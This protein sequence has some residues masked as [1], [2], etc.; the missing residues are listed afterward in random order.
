MR[1]RDPRKVERRWW[2]L[3]ASVLATGVSGGLL[4]WSF[5]LFIEPM[6]ADLGWSRAQIS[7]GFSLAM[8]TTGVAAPFVGRWVDARGARSAIIVGAVA[9][10]GI[11]ILMASM[12]AL[13]QWYLYQSIAG[14]VR[15]LVFGIPFQTLT[16]GWF[17]QQRGMALA[18]L[19]TGLALGAIILVPIMR[20]V[21]DAIDWEGGLIV[22]GVAIVAVILPIGLFVVRDP[23][24]VASRSTATDSP[25]SRAS[26]AFAGI[27]A[28]AALRDPR[29]W[30]LSFGIG[31]FNLAGIT[32]L[33]HGVP[34]YE[35]VG[36]SRSWA[37]A[38]VSIA[39][40]VGL[41]RILTGMVA[42]RMASL[43]L[44]AA[45]LGVLF[46]TGVAVLMVDASTVG[47][48]LFVVLFALGNSGAQMFQPLLMGRAFGT[49]HLGTII[50]ASSLLT[51]AGLI[52]GPI[53]AGA[54]FDE[55]GS[56]DGALA[57]MIASLGAAVAL[58]L[59]A[60][61]RRHPAPSK[62]P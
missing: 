21:V 54:I 33:V 34:F 45:G 30:M 44:W 11:T 57:M 47:I 18:V 38:L 26:P 2:I 6:E 15:G 24:P 39:A 29:F 52:V 16:I 31:L 53:A 43:E 55:T 37:A 20:I 61:R 36:V 42:D 62:R 22:S 25:D 7:L 17:G 19:G 49:L 23:L 10:G 3:A 40:A 4:F 58:F 12:N 46:L 51:T 13:W 59:I 14:L 28:R 8:L 32:W 5:G 60:S 9:V 41:V 1:L 35:S 27:T 48:G 50:G 56:Y